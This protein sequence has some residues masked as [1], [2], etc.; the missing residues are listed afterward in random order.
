MNES[1]KVKRFRFFNNYI[2][3]FF[4]FVYDIYEVILMQALVSISNVFSAI[5]PI[6]GVA[7]LIALIIVLIKLIQ[8]L[9]KVSK[10]MEKVDSTVEIVKG[11]TADMNVTVKTVNNV[12]FSVEA[13][14]VSLE[15]M[16][17]S[18]AANWTKQFEQ[19]KAQINAILDRLDKKDSKKEEEAVVVQLNE[20][21]NETSEA[22]K[23]TEEFKEV[24]EEK[25]D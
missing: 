20:E 18:I 19:I 2:E 17:K 14:R 11:Y 24:V 21:V 1:A 4:I 12:A 7:A 13:V 10:T 25:E 6:L 22:E 15:R 5:L 9:T 3:N 16:I 23:L 8:L